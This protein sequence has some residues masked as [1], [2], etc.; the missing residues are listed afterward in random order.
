MSLDAKNAIYTPTRQAQTSP[1]LPASHFLGNRHVATAPSPVFANSAVNAEES[2]K[3]TIPLS[4]GTRIPA[5]HFIQFQGN[6]GSDPVVYSGMFLDEENALQQLPIPDGWTRHAH[7]CT[8]QHKNDTGSKQIESLPSGEGTLT[9][10]RILKTPEV[11]Y[12]LVEPPAAIRDWVAAQKIATP[13]WH[14][15]IATAP[16]IKP[17]RARDMAEL[18]D[19]AIQAAGIPVES[20]NTLTLPLQLNF[21]SGGFTRDKQIKTSAE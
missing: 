5:H 2:K 3:S 9:V 7:H 1:R 10:T 18:S 20:V 11:I 21:L 19:A 16:G 8:I 6:N 12:A 13:P 15:T 14:V 4:S 17:A